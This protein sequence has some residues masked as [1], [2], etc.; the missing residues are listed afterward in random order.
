MNTAATPR[1][2][3]R[4]N[5]TSTGQGAINIGFDLHPYIQATPGIGATIYD[6]LTLYDLTDGTAIHWLPGGNAAV[7]LSEYSGPPWQITETSD[8]YSLQDPLGLDF[9]DQPGGTFAPGVGH[10][11]ISFTAPQGHQMQVD[12]M[13][14]DNV[15]VMEYPTDTNPHDAP[16]PF[17]VALLFVGLLGLVFL[18][19]NPIA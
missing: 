1:N 19:R 13:L 7:D 5:F 8:P 18:R 17:S 10:F 4:I 2:D 14:N 3:L 12:L 11:G 16:E 6:Y 15:Q 9:P